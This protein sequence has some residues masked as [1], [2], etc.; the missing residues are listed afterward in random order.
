MNALRKK[1]MKQIVGIVLVRN[2]D[3]H[4]DWALQNILDFCDRI[5]VLD[6]Y[7]T[8]RTYK[9]VSELA[10]AH[11]KIELRRWRNAKTSQ[12]AL[13]KFYETNT[14]I[15]GVDGD[16][17]FCPIGLAKIRTRIMQ[18]EFD[19]VYRI[20]GNCLNCIN[21]NFS[22]KTADGYPSP[23]AT[24]GVKLYN[25]QLVKGWN[26]DR[27]E[28]LHGHPIFTA[29]MK[30]ESVFIGNKNSFDDSPLR[31]LHLCFMQRSS[32]VTQ[33]PF[34]PIGFFRRRAKAKKAN[35]TG[36]PYN[37]RP[38]PGDSIEY[39]MQHYAVGNIETFNIANF[40]K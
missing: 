31:F 38:G 28:R 2:E 23:P 5:I 15:F 18:G 33:Y 27:R 9:I 22:N 37:A 21:I 25:F 6:N 40:I 29:A 10:K 17:I 24:G 14:Y 30:T 7:S 20:S 34:S 3:Y 16:E 1:F 26:N 13:T 39:K 12:R 32:G 19:S 8:D 36:N 35:P 11:R 4:I